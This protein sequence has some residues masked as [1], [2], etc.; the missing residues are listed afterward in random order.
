MKYLK[1]NYIL[2]D[3]IF[4]LILAIFLILFQDY[5]FGAKMND[6]NAIYFCVIVSIYFIIAYYFKRK[7][8]PDYDDL[9]EFYKKG[10]KISGY[11][12]KKSVENKD[13]YKKSYINWTNFNLIF[14]SLELLI[15]LIFYFIGYR[16]YNLFRI[17]LC[18]VFAIQIIG[19]I[20]TLIR[21]KRF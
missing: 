3:V 10:W 2:V 19:Y 17:H 11:Y 4:L 21:E 16:S 15:I 8:I 18:A 1:R 6:D 9:R 20:I 5:I 7:Y 13:V 14:L 12:S